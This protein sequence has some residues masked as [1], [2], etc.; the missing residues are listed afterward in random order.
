MDRMPIER[1]EH[2]IVARDLGVNTVRIKS[3]S[4][5]DLDLASGRAHAVCAEHHGGKTEL[6][7]TLAGRM[8]RTEGTLTVAGIDA[9]ALSRLKRVRAIAGLAFF[10]R[11]NEVEQN[12][13][14]STVVSAELSLAGKPAGR[15]EANAFLGAWGLGE[16]ADKTV[17]E[18][19]AYDY[20]LLGN[21]MYS[22]MSSSVLVG[23]CRR[24][25]V[26]S[27]TSHRLCG[28]MLVAYPAAIPVAPFTS[29]TG[30]GTGRTVGSFSV[31]SKFGAISTVSL[32]RSSS[33]ICVTLASLTSV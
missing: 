11:V 21:G 2:F 6:L 16:L 19:A 5:V 3:F 17:S 14:T 1:D 32:S 26:A 15:A 20:D 4:H 18:L 29:I 10:E 22:M 25:I 31:S 30:K 7:L 9:T 27:T 13:R 8:H 28:G 33:M 24:Q 12:L 23:F